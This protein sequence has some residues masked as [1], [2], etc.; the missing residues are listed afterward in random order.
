[1]EVGRDRQVGVCP[2]GFQFALVLLHLTSSFCSQLQ[3]LLTCSP[4]KPTSDKEQ[5]PLKDS[6]PA[7]IIEEGLVPVINPLFHI[8][9][10]GSADGLYPE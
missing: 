8:T 9:Q 7:P 1:M 3:S 2:H 4:F 5:H 6:L 10:R